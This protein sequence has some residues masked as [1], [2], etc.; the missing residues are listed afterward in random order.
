MRHDA[1]IMPLLFFGGLIYFFVVHLQGNI[2]NI[3]RHIKRSI[4]ESPMVRQ[5]KN[6]QAISIQVLF[7]LVLFISFLLQL[8]LVTLTGHYSAVC[9]IA[10]LNCKIINIKLFPD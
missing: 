6:L 5:I 9:T 4:K 3:T 7:G 10:C 2:I 1:I 8:N